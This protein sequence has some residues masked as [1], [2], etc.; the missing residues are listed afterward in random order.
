MENFH[1]IEFETANPSTQGSGCKVF[2]SIPMTLMIVLMADTPSHP[3]LKATLAGYIHMEY[4][5]HYQ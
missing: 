4:N 2:R 3:D 5:I 1:I